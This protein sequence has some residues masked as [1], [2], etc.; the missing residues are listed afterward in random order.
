MHGRLHAGPR[1]R[2]RAV[3]LHV[4]KQV[5]IARSKVRAVLW[6]TKEFSST[7]SL[8]AI[9]T[10]ELMDDFGWHLFGHPPYSP[11][12][13]PSLFHLFLHMKTWLATQ[14]F[15]DDEELHAGVLGWLKSQGAIFYD[16]GINK[17][18]YRYDKY[19]NL[20]RDYV[21]K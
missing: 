15:D 19:L 13:A 16:D 2:R 4:W 17:L 11:N 12:L 6:M 5:K 3:L 21:E 7:C 1:H 9:R 8:T 14:C 18:V 10:R 20:Y